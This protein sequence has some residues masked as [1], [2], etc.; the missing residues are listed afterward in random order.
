MIMTGLSRG[1]VVSNVSLQCQ[2]A[3][4]VHFLVQPFLVELIGVEFPYETY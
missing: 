2:V 1:R 4:F 3:L